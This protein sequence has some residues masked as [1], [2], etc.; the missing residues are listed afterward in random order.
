LRAIETPKLF[1]PDAPRTTAS[2]LFKFVIS[3]FRMI[4]YRLMGWKHH[5]CDTARDRLLNK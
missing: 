1:W 4:N 2:L 3:T 5:I